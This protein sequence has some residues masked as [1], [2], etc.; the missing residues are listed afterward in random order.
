MI[1]ITDASRHLLP[2]HFASDPG[3]DFTWWSEPAD[4]RL[5]AGAALSTA[6]HLRLVCRYMAIEALNVPSARR[7]SSTSRPTST[8]LVQLA[9]R[10]SIAKRA[11]SLRR[12]SQ[13]SCTAPAADESADETCETDMDCDADCPVSMAQVTSAAH[14]VCARLQPNA[15]HQYMKEMVD[16]YLQSARRRFEES[17]LNG[18][19]AKPATANAAISSTQATG[20]G[21]DA[22]DTRGVTVRP[23]QSKQSF[24]RER[25][26]S[27]ALSND[28]LVVECMNGNCAQLASH[29]TNYLCDSCFRHQQ[30]VGTSSAMLLLLRFSFARR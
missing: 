13:L 18:T 3:A 23:S 16:T 7:A 10:L 20:N 6:Q 29:S 25:G 24:R 27:R 2:V 12:R 17:R 26:I 28:S 21:L 22:G 5:A 8:R 11:S 1:P 30:E 9:K 15:Y 14:L 19:T 4:D